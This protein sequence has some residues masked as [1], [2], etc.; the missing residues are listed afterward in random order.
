MSLFNIDELRAS[1][2]GAFMEKA[3]ALLKEEGKAKHASAILI[4]EQILPGATKFDVF[5]SHSFHDARLVLGLKREIEALGYSVYVDWLADAH[6]DREAVSPA[7]AAVLRTRMRGSQ[8]LLF[9]A[10][11]NSI[12]STWTPWELG[13][14]DADNG[15]VAIIPVTQEPRFDNSFVG[16]EYLGLYPYVTKDNNTD[17]QARLWVHRSPQEYVVFR[18]WLDGKAPHRRE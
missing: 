12:S 8:C 3:A 18:H 7:T 2:E 4:N 10:T 6:L 14:K 13:F 15:R 9:A 5:L 1:G 11:V 17:N 16:R